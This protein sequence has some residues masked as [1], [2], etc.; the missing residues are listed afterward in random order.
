MTGNLPDGLR[1]EAGMTEDLVSRLRALAERCAIQGY[2]A[3]A[4]MLR[5]AAAELARLTAIA[6]ASADESGSG[7]TP[8]AWRRVA[9]RTLADG[10]ES[11][12][13][14]P[15]FHALLQ[16]ERDADT[17]E[18]RATMAEEVAAGAQE[19][20]AE[21]GR[22]VVAL[23]ERLAVAE[24]DAQQWRLLWRAV[25]QDMLR[26][27]DKAEAREQNEAIAARLDWEA[28]T[29]GP[30]RGSARMSPPREEGP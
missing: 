24:A 1:R 20:L 14:G 22:T 17:N 11:W 23:R 18:V 15:L 3:R 10:I 12:E 19:E 6:N 5:D 16:A 4:V 7:L 8:E 25:R 30:L 26:E 2:P 28:R 21:Q 9:N 13:L 27:R 29:S